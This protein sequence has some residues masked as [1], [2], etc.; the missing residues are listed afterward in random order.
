MIT[1]NEITLLSLEILTYIIGILQLI[2]RDFY[3][4]DQSY[5]RNF[6]FHIICD[7]THQKFSLINISP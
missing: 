7:E 1:Y 5:K 6:L 4:I 2:S 3:N